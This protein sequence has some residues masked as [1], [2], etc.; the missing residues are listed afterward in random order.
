MG[1]WVGSDHGFFYL[2]PGLYIMSMDIMT[3]IGS[4]MDDEGHARRVALQNM[5]H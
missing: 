2:L 3:W 4:R 5:I 1:F